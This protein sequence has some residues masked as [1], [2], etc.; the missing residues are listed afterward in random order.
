[1]T[2]ETKTI[3][4]L[5]RGWKVRFPN[6]GKDSETLS[7]FDAPT[8][9]TEDPRTR[10]YSGEVV[11]TKSFAMDGA[12]LRKARKIVLDFGE[13]TPVAAEPNVKNGMSALL[14]APVREAAIVIVN[15]VRVGSV[16]HPPYTLDLTN[17]LHAGDNSIEVR[18]GNTAIN[19]L[20]GRAPADYRLLWARYGQ[21]FSPQDMDH[22]E[23]LPSGIFGPVHLIE[24]N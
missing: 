23:P 20:A 21:R 13:G 14:D 3:G 15:G 1:M 19:G 18:V 10:F 9:W 5:T 7:E 8:S 6:L 4:D 12:E 2:A 11:Y 22:L 24:T 17:A 16:W